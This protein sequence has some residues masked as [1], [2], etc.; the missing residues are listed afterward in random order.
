MVI[1]VSNVSDPLLELLAT[2]I[3][4]DAALKSSIDQTLRSAMLKEIRKR[5]QTP[6]EN[7]SSAPFLAWI[8]DMRPLELLAASFSLLEKIIK[9]F[10]S[11]VRAAVAGN[12][13]AHDQLVAGAEFLIEISLGINQEANRQYEKEK[14]RW[15]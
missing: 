14:R 7:S 2:K 3:F 12:L 15:N 10:Q 8:P 13:S 5:A 1:E 4:E 6:A 11:A 9:L